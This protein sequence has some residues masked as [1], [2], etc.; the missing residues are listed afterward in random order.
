MRHR[1]SDGIIVCAGQRPD[2]EGSSPSG[3]REGRYIRKRGN[4][5]GGKDV[6]RVTTL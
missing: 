2:Q 3:A 4:A 5:A 6:T 1:E